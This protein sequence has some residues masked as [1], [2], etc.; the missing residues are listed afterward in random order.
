MKKLILLLIIAL[1]ISSCSDDDTNSTIIT[2]LEGDWLLVHQH[3]G[4]SP[5][6][7]EPPGDIRNQ[8]IKYHFTGNI[9]KKTKN[10]EPFGTQI[11]FT[12]IQ[13]ADHYL[14]NYD[15]AKYSISLKFYNDN[16]IAY[17]T[18]N[19]IDIGYKLEKIQ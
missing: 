15:E 1:G 8:N 4:D 13:E 5:V 10:G 18:Y 14:F 9:Q 7:Q 2:P 3:G 19:S 12:L 17:F 11:T 16:T 6:G